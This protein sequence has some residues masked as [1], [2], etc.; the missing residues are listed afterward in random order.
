MK[1]IELTK[2]E[3]AILDKT[4]RE[5]QGLCISGDIEYDTCLLAMER[6]KKHLLTDDS[7]INQEYKYHSFCG[8]YETA[9]NI[10]NSDLCWGDKYHM[11]FSEEISD[12]VSFEWVDL[13]MDYEDDVLAFMNGFDIFM[14]KQKIIFE[15]VSNKKQL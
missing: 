13:D 1:T 10:V 8:V 14:E 5:M 6:L 15:Q 3:I 12:K 2:E 4:I 7:K 9:K 11:I